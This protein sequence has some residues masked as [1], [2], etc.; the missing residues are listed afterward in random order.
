MCFCRSGQ[1]H[2][3]ETIN[4]HTAGFTARR[5]GLL[6]RLTSMLAPMNL[7]SSFRPGV[8]LQAWRL[9]S[10][11]EVW[12]VLDS[13][14]ASLLGLWSPTEDE[15]KRNTKRGCLERIAARSVET[16]DSAP[17]LRLRFWK[18]HRAPSRRRAGHA[19][20]NGAAGGRDPALTRQQ[21]VLREPC[22]CRRERRNPGDASRSLPQNKS[23]RVRAPCVLEATEPGATWHLPSAAGRPTEIPCYGPSAPYLHV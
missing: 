18:T 5:A 20:P 7:S 9:A 6:Q 14:N 21:P 13:A 4:P 23:P 12:L 15:Q 3:A 22:R 11:I 16:A 17:C 1:G 19:G 2:E 10:E 8:S